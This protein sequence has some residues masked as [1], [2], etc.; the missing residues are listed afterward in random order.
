ML[1]RL[2]GS[3]DVIPQAIDCE[4]ISRLRYVEAACPR[5]CQKVSDIG[6]EP[7]IVAADRPQAERPVRTLPCQQTRNCILDALVDI[8]IG[9]K[10]RLRSKLVDIEH[11]HSAACD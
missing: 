5:P 3:R 10:L 2:R 6:V 4:R 1:G 8:A 9:G 11:C 7:G